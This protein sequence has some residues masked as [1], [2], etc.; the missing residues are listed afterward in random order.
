MYAPFA[1]AK[2]Y[3]LNQFY[4]LA[5][6]IGKGDKMTYYSN[7]MSRH[8]L[9][10]WLGILPGWSWLQDNEHKYDGWR[11]TIEL[12]MPRVKHTLTLKPDAKGIISGIMRR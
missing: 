9:K 4:L 7:L 12:T 6:G 10:P 5:L 1:K 2:S 3:V 8:N 11:P